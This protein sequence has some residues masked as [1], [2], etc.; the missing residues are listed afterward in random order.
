MFLIDKV[1]ICKRGAR[2]RGKGGTKLAKGM[3]VR[4]EEVKP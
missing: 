3:Y 2:R 1:A 4:G